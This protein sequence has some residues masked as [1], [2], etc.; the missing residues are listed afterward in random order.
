M[1]CLSSKNFLELQ[2]YTGSLLTLCVFDNL[3]S[4]LLCMRITLER[5]APVRLTSV[6]PAMSF[7]YLKASRRGCIRESRKSPSTRLV[8]AQPIVCITYVLPAR[9]LYTAQDWQSSQGCEPRRLR[10]FVD[11]IPHV[12][13]EILGHTLVQQRT[14]NGWQQ[15]M[16]SISKHA[17]PCPGG[18]ASHVRFKK[19]ACVNPFAIALCAV[20]MARDYF[21]RFCLGRAGVLSIYHHCHSMESYLHKCNRAVVYPAQ[22]EYIQKVGHDVIVQKKKWA[23]ISL[24][25]TVNETAFPQAYG[26]RLLQILTPLRI[27]ADNRP[28]NTPAGCPSK[29]L[30]VHN[31][32]S[33]LRMVHVQTRTSRYDFDESQ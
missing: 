26:A 5:E 18:I 10:D 6:L 9:I 24:L 30:F 17:R 32:M 13:R 14:P 29:Y 22:N 28:S 1:F 8:A 16:N 33:I 19:H 31:H 4:Q 11:L 7:V 25:A 12:V 27:A 23:T 3:A 2:F 15:W 21:L 20:P